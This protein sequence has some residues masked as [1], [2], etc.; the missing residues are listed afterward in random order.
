MDISTNKYLY[1]IFELK[2]VIC[3]TIV[4]F[5][6]TEDSYWTF[7]RLHLMHLAITFPILHTFPEPKIYSV[8]QSYHTVT[9]ILT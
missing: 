5:A 2:C 4:L 7:R 1:D 8:D 6:A 9:P 3:H